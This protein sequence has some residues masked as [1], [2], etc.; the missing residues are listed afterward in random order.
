MLRMS[1]SQSE[2]NVSFYSTVLGKTYMYFTI[3]Y[4]SL[5]SN[6]IL[7]VC[8][9]FV[10]VYCEFD[11]INPDTRQWLQ[12]SFVILDIFCLT[13][14]KAFRLRC[15]LFC[16]VNLEVLRDSMSIH[17]SL[18]YPSYFRTL[19]MILLWRPVF[20]VVTFHR[21]SYLINPPHTKQS[22]VEN[23]SFIISFYS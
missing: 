2:K 17:T 3:C 7:H 22:S 8:V 11:I 16:L 14:P 10:F 18:F 5:N 21:V 12:T 13:I 20:F 4:F 6:S 19:S 1:Y 23:C 9:F 15:F